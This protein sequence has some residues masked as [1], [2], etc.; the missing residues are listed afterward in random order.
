LAKPSAGSRPRG[1]QRL[2][3]IFL[4]AAAALLALAAWHARA[5]EAPEALARPIAPAPGVYVF[6]DKPNLDPRLYP[7]V[8]GHLKFAWD[9]LEPAPGEIQWPIIE[10]WVAQEAALGKPVGIGFVT[11]NGVDA[12]GDL[13]PRWVY[14]EAP[15]ARVLC[16]NNWSIPRYWS[17]AYLSRYERFVRAVGAVY[18]GDPRIAWV[19]IGVGLYGETTPDREIFYPCLED[20]GLTSALWV[21]TV[22]RIT[23]LYR[24][25]FPTTPLFLQMAPYFASEAERRAFTDYAASLGVGLKHNGL[26]ADT[27]SLV[28]DDPTYSLYA[29]GQYDPFLTHGD[30][31]PLAWETYDYM[32][33]DLPNLLWGVLNALDK[34]ADYIVANRGLVEPPSRWPYLEFANRYL[35]RT[36]ADT[37]SV[38]VALREARPENTWYP[39]RGNFSFYLYQ[40]DTVPGGRTVPL[41][42]VDASPEGLYARRTNCGSGHCLMAFDVDERFLFGGRNAVTVTVTY[43]DQGTGAWELEYDAVEAPY[44]SAGTVQ[45]ANTR[46]W[47]KATFVLPDAHFANRQA[48]GDRRA[49]TDFRIVARGED[50]ILHMVDVARIATEGAPTWYLASFQ[51]GIRGYAGAADT[52]LSSA[53]PHANFGWDPTLTLGAGEVQNALV[54]FDLASLPPGAQVITAALE[55]RL[56]SATGEAPVAVDAFGV[57]RHWEEGEATWNLAFAG[58]PWGDAGCRRAGVD[59][60]AALTDRKRLVY[61]DRPLLL[62][63]TALAHAW[64]ADPAANHGLLLRALSRQAATLRFGSSDHPDPAL[65]PRL[66]VRYALPAGAPT[67]SPTPEETPTPTWT[68]T[69]TP[70]TATPTGTPSPTPTATFTPG[71]PPTV[72]AFQQGV[73]GYTG[74]QDT[75]L[76]AWAPNANFH[77]GPTLGL[78]TSVAENI[79]VALLRFDLRAIPPQAQVVQA[80][81]EFYVANRSNANW[82]WAEAHQVLRPWTAAQATWN[83]ASSG[84]LWSVPGCNGSGTDR[85]EGVHDRTY[86]AASGQWYDLDLTDLVQF[87]VGN[88]GQNYGLLLRSYSSGSVEYELASSEAENPA[89][90][91]RLVVRYRFVPTPTPTWTGTPPTPTPTATPTATA[92]HTPSPTPT[93]TPS[94]TATESATPSPTP[95]ATESPTAS[96]T[97]SPSATWTPSPTPTPAVEPRL[98]LPFLQ[99]GW[100][101]G[102]TPTPTAT[103]YRLS[104]SG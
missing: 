21:Q 92:T 3:A 40:D 104:P 33:S 93:E 34:H 73:G 97:P 17:E 13:V 28:Y 77:T 68:V 65:R 48:G 76:S 57:L 38:W 67:P 6:L 100:A 90:R 98:W 89:L 15:E 72:V 7:I 22:N 56:L 39:Q 1:L 37:P 82:L 71:P 80:T 32:L 11:Y 102:P 87:W 99:R 60:R 20:A 66:W 41:W 52:T 45:K 19:E 9:D 24:R 49:G 14:R 51:E 55:L 101:G 31:V 58:V 47:R 61:P 5:S 95:T 74:A 8:G 91:P 10:N 75:T 70:P 79:K 83:Q 81:L 43:F 63:V 35:G 42:N 26:R 103:P 78:R 2:G 30:R 25:A 46:T 53:Q 64:A 18:D 86:M 84:V 96:P 62:D 23:E 85:A 27:N 29:S 69:G 36:P 94:P 88:P 50:V 59:R 4:G 44:R 54:R 16:A 12:G